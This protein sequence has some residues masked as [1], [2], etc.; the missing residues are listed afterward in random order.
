MTNNI[1]ILGCGFSGMLTA[2]AFAKQNIKVT[3]LENRSVASDDFCS[4]VRTTALTPESIK[5]LDNINIWQ[6]IEQQVGKMLDVYVVD[7]KAPEMLDLRDTKENKPLGYIVNN[8]DFKRALLQK[9]QEN[10]LIEIV[11]QF[12]YKKITSLN[13]QTVIECSDNKV[14]KSDLLIVCNGHNSQVCSYYF[15][16]KIEKS[17]KQIALTFNIKHSKNH[18]DCAMEH[19][20][21]EGPFA[22]LPLKSQNHS[23]IIWTVREEQASLLLSLP[24]DEIEYLVNRNCGTSLGTVKIASKISSFPLKARVTNKYFH[25]RIVL[26]ADSAHIIHPLAGQGLNQ[27]IKDI[28]ALTRLIASLGISEET[29]RQYQKAREED[30]FVM[31]MITE[32]L[33]MVFSNHSNVL[34]YFRR[35]GL[36]MIN[37]IPIVKNW[38]LQYAMGQR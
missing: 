14:I 6:E 21:P 9:V 24:N 8:S 27:G 12:S 29:L 18:E 13:S 11:D 32:N 20:M 36:D 16:N 31:Y 4:D 25:N 23:S 34:W 1:S 37:N 7:N 19:F 30:N 2:L 5:F 28:D 17:Y 38:L 26:V 22:V 35:L 33:K 3:I 15:A 10:P